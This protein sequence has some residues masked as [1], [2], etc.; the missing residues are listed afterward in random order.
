MSLQVSKTPLLLSLS[1]PFRVL[2]GDFDAEETPTADSFSSAAMGGAAA[3][4]QL[5]RQTVAD[6]NNIPSKPAT[7]PAKADS[8]VSVT[9]IATNP[10]VVAPVKTAIEPNTPTV[11][12]IE[13]PK[14]ESPRPSVAASSPRTQ[15]PPSDSPRAAEV[16]G[17]EERLLKLKMETKK[18]EIESASKQEYLRNLDQRLADTAKQ[19]QEKT[20]QLAKLSHESTHAAVSSD[21]TSATA[22]K[23]GSVSDEEESQRLDSTLI[24]K[25]RE[26][27]E[28]EDRLV[29][30]EELLAQK[31][32][33]KEQ[34][35]T[36]MKRL[37]E[38]LLEKESQLTRLE[39]HFEQT[40]SALKK[41]V[42][43][44][45]SNIRKLQKKVLSLAERDAGPGG[46]LMPDNS[47]GTAI[48]AAGSDMAAQVVD[49]KLKKSRTSSA[50]HE[51]QRSRDSSSSSSATED[52]RSSEEPRQIPASVSSPDTRHSRKHS[53]AGDEKSSRKGKETVAADRERKSIGGEKDKPQG[54]EVR[55]ACMLLRDRHSHLPYSEIWTHA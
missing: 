10:A 42:E 47:S 34:I 8:M 52:T 39:K 4:R 23:D 43:K 21:S 53:Q 46:A 49:P 45:E 24:L 3:L 30:A 19:I 55:K 50:A 20:D 33:R 31:M 51:K 35:E 11:I 1:A 25:K 32:E 44:N 5:R 16:A 38:R 15:Q 28:L 29:T 13:V 22:S 18:I 27:K 37:M 6:I 36:M 54:K 2:N 48:A 26:I 12:S 7:L 40:R 17:L 9:A 41:E 14:V